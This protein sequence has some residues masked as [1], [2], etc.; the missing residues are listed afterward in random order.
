MKRN[1]KIA[2]AGMAFAFVAGNGSAQDGFYNNGY[3]AQQQGQQ[4]YNNGDAYYQIPNNYQG[5]Y[6]PQQEYRGAPSYYGTQDSSSNDMYQST[7]D[8]YYFYYH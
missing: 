7:G 6:Y 2:L 3:P 4:P 8:P 5:E 1:V